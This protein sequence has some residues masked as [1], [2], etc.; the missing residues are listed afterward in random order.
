M[1]HC[2]LNYYYAWTII[3][4][5]FETLFNP[6]KLSM[7]DVYAMFLFFW[8]F[9]FFPNVQKRIFLCLFCVFCYFF[10]LIHAESPIGNFSSYCG[11]IGDIMSKIS[12]DNTYTMKW[13]KI[14]SKKKHTNFRDNCKKFTAKETLSTI[15]HTYII[16]K[17]FGFISLRVVCIQ[18][19]IP[20]I[21]ITTCFRH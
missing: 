16:K 3:M 13:T 8:Q 12:N 21:I 15:C 14:K 4:I 10:C 6:V 7:F 18:M 5:P 17:F 20:C 11:A 2:I 1:V 9:Y 19:N